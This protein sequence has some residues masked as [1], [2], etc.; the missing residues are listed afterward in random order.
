MAEIG[1]LAALVATGLIKLNDQCSTQGCRL[2]AVLECPSCK[3]KYCGKHASES[4]SECV[5]CHKRLVATQAIKV[6]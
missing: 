3:T 1:A 6:G 2:T 5:N 4:D